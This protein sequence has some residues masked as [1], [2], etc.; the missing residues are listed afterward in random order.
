LAIFL[1]L[2]F[3]WANPAR[4][5]TSVEE[6]LNHV[7]EAPSMVTLSFKFDKIFYP[8]SPID[9][10]DFSFSVAPKAPNYYQDNVTKESLKFDSALS[11]YAQ[12]I[13]GEFLQDSAPANMVWKWLKDRDLGFL[14]IRRAQDSDSV[15]VDIHDFFSFKQRAEK[16]V[17]LVNEIENYIE[18]LNERP[19]YKTIVYANSCYLNVHLNER[20]LFDPVI[21]SRV[22]QLREAIE[23]AKELCHEIKCI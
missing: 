21:N 13:V 20:L 7:F 8:S 3:A 23:N 19:T 6:A 18:E 11:F 5:N 9:I 15:T 22:Y 12:M 16:V 14:N 10:K 4:L 2:S 17:A 1:S